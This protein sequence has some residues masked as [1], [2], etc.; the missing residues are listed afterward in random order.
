MY[1]M[2][3]VCSA[4]GLRLRDRNAQFF[5]V[6]VRAISD[7]YNLDYNANTASKAKSNLLGSI[8]FD[9]D[10]NGNPDSKAASNIKRDIM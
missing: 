7:L 1:C 5:S 6:S 10:Y 3:S 8:V 9:H 4:R 2:M